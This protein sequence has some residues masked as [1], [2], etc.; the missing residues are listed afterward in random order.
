MSDPIYRVVGAAAL[1]KRAALGE[2]EDFVKSV[3]EYAERAKSDL[4][5]A[6]KDAIFQAQGKAQ[7][8][9]ELVKKLED[10]IVLD[11]QYRRRG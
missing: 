5:V 10:C 11:E 1:L 3:R 6:P 7:V 8:L 4:V 2:Y 9:I